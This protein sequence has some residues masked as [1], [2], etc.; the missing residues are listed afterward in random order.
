M[1]DEEEV[2][3]KTSNVSLVSLTVIPVCYEAGGSPTGAPMKTLK[4]HSIMTGNEILIVEDSPIQAE[5]L[6][7]ILERHRYRVS[8]SAN[9]KEALAAIAERKPAFIIS[10]IVMPEMDGYELCRKIKTDEGY[11]DIPVI[12][13]TTLSDPHDVVRGLECGADNFVSKPYDEE[14]LVS[15]IEHMNAERIQ[16]ERENT[17][18]ELELHFGGQDYVLH[19]D[20]RQIL[21]LLL[22]TYETAIRKNRELSQAR[23]ELHELNEQLKAANREL[24]AFGYTVSHDLRSPLNVISLCCQEMLGFHKE[25]LDAPVLEDIQMIFAETDRM[26]QL[27]NT[28]LNFSQLTRIEMT[29]EDVDLSGMAMEIARQ[30]SMKQPER[31]VTFC[32]AAGI[33]ANGDER[34]LQV[35]LEN[36]LGNAWKYTGK[37]EEALVEF[38]MEETDGEKEY[39]VK[40]NGAGFDMGFAG[41]LFRPFQ[42]LH[43]PEEFKGTG[44]GLATVQ[45]IIQRHGGKVRAEG[46]VDKGATFYFT[47]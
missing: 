40:D 5:Q 19:A 20:R 9:G 10:D 45:R 34:L 38:G 1:P 13:L 33:T 35:V 11:R 44:I 3:R 22:S 16:P 6:R 43:Q 29:K 18:E 39:F 12:L 41:N 7:Y 2:R 47:L 30:L 36:L 31:R 27:I 17:T 21:N 8:T 28:L 4:E 42:R 32:I 24:E 25:S 46:E 23:D 15:L 26:N 37:N 14:Y